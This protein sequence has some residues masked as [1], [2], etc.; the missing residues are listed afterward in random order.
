MLVAR[1]PEPVLY[2]AN[3]RN[4]LWSPAHSDGMC[5][6]RPKQPVVFTYGAG[7][8]RGPNWCSDE[9]CLRAA[10]R[11]CSPGRATSRMLANRCELPLPPALT[12]FVCCNRTNHTPRVR[13]NSPLREVTNQLGAQLVS[14]SNGLSLRGLVTLAIPGETRKWNPPSYCV[15]AEDK[16]RIGNGNHRKRA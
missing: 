6:R 16:G 10:G 2:D 15:G 12:T 8:S 3:S 11:P 13:A 7:R 5:R 9:K 1:R 4:R 14:N